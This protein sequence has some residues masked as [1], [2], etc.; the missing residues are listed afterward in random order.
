[1]GVYDWRDG[2]RLKPS[3]GREDDLYLL[4]T[5]RVE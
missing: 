3:D 4:A 1:V 5:V 2:A